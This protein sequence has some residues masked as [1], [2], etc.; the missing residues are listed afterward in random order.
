[1]GIVLTKNQINKFSYTTFEYSHPTTINGILFTGGLAAHTSNIEVSHSTFRN[2]HG[3]D[4]LNIKYSKLAVKDSLFTN[5]EFDALDVDAGQ[6]EISNNK[7]IQNGNDGIDISFS[8]IK[9]DNNYI[10]GAGDKCIS[11][12]EQSNPQIQNSTL[13][14]CPTGI[15]VK[16]GSN[17]TI[18]RV[19]ISNT[20]I[21]LAAYQKKEIFTGGTILLKQVKLENNRQDFDVDAYSKL[22]KV[23]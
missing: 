4:G 7:F 11:V 15:A 23:D 9:I 18:E 6:G 17:A 5:N 16:D 14:T 21:A 3:D 1:M 19:N 12:G 22:T 20:T 8:K 10:Q 13:T 2:N